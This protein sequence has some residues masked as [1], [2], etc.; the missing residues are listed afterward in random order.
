MTSRISSYRERILKSRP[1]ICTERAFFYTNAYKTQ[2]DKPLILKRAYA[3]KD[4]L[5]GMSI[6]IEEEDLIAGNH[7]SAIYAAPIFPEYAVEWIRKEINE[8]EKRPGDAF[9]PDEKT[10][11]ELLEL[12]DYWE[13]ITTLDKGRALM[14]EDLLA[15]HEAGIIRAEGNLTSGDAHIAAH[16]RKILKNGLG[17]FTQETD[18]KL[19]ETDTVG[20]EGLKKHF[21]YKSVGI[22]LRGFQT[23]IRRFSALASRMAESEP[24][25]ERKRE[26]ELISRNCALI[27]SDPPQTFY[28]ALQLSYFVQLV[29]Q[30]ESNGHSQSM[31]RV[32]QYLY[33]F[34][35]ND[36]DAGILD[37]EFAMELLENVWLKLVSMKK[38]PLLVP[39]PFFRRRPPLSECHHRR[40][41]PGRFGRCQ[42]TELS[43]TEIRRRNT[44]DPA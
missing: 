32:D 17:W 3:L 21:F 18:R 7:S 6:R 1:T 36:R 22:S 4:T 24:E 20:A 13:G 15:I 8:F 44:A 10:K 34:Y 29:L 40:T 26:L 11:T 39:Y 5:E 9:Y 23:F 16:F 27:A 2:R 35:K 30:I 12:C 37:E 28:Q 38:N 33:P 41:A 43:H 25:S 19:A 14:T 42:R 31:G